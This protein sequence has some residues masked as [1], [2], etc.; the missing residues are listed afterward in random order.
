M[1][2]GTFRA[3]KRA[4]GVLRLGGQLAETQ[5]LGAGE[6]HAGFADELDGLVNGDPPVSAGRAV[7]PDAA[8]VHP[9]FDR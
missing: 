5:Q 9:P 8:V 3:R 7:S 4:A 6:R 1:L 2:R